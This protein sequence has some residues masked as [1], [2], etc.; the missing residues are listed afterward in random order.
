M[1]LKRREAASPWR[2][3]CQTHDAHHPTHL[4]QP[5]TRSL[6]FVVMLPQPTITRGRVA[7]CNCQPPRMPNA[8]PAGL[9]SPSAKG[10]AGIHNPK[11]QGTRLSLGGAQCIRPRFAQSVVALS[12]LPVEYVTQCHL[13]FRKKDNQSKSSSLYSFKQRASKGWCTADRVTAFCTRLL[14]C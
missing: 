6:R 8:R 2:G 11:A 5:L 9:G 3:M 13:T 4:I 1:V 14:P 7:R 12:S 10:R